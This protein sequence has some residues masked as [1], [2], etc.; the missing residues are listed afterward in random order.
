MGNF[1][2]FLLTLL[3]IVVIF[4]FIVFGGM[5]YNKKHV[6]DHFGVSKKTIGKWIELLPNSVLKKEWVSLKVISG[7]DF[8]LLQLQWE[9]H[10]LKSMNKEQIWR[11]CKSDYQTLSANVKMNLEKIEISLEAWN[12]LSIFPPAV[13]ERIISVMG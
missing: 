13:C 7:F 12:S 11:E 8:F 2:E 9:S 3:L 4:V 5:I 6:A 10:G 1:L